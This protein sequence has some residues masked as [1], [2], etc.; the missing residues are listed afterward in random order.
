MPG[1]DT[2]GGVRLYPAP[3]TTLSLTVVSGSLDVSGTA[4]VTVPKSSNPADYCYKYDGY[5]C[6]ADAAGNFN[7]VYQCTAAQQNSPQLPTASMVNGCN[8]RIWLHQLP[9][10]DYVN[11]GGWV[12][13]V[14][15]MSAG[16]IPSADDNPQNIQVTTNSSAC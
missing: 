4:T 8:V 16:A 5:V 12:Y 9:Y 15:P 10:P 2:S 13:C 14:S 11:D 6:T 1:P 3:G 7:N